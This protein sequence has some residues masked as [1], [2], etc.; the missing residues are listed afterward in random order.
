MFVK[1]ASLLFGLMFMIYSLIDIPNRWSTIDLSTFDTIAANTP[2]VAKEISSL[3]KKLKITK[4]TFNE[5]VLYGTASFYAFKFEGRRTAAGEVFE[6]KKM[7]A[8]CNALPLG[9]WIKVTNLKNGNSVIVKTNDRLA[10][11]S[12]RL[13]DLTMAATKRLGFKNAGLTRV[14]VEVLPSDEIDG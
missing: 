9:T 13:V 2:K 4:K 1:I 8:A 7:T 10:K 12:S 11:K 5:T 3:N 6:H 14:K